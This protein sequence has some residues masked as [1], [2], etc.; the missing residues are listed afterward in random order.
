MRVILFILQK[1]FIQIFRNK[2][3]LPLIFVLPVVQ[4]LIL[5]NAATFELKNINLVVVNH[6]MT[7]T[8]R[9]LVS[10]FEG[11]AF[12]NVK[13][14]LSM[15]EA[16]DDLLGNKANVILYIPANFERELL[17][18][19]RASVQFLINAIDGMAAGLI[20]VY[21]GSIVND[22]HQNLLVEWLDAKTHVTAMPIDVSQRYWFNPNLEY[23][24]YMLPGILVILVTII[25]MFLTAIN[26]VREKEQG[27]I[28]QINVTPILKYQ[29][30]TGKLIPFLII[31]LFELAFGLAI[32][33]IFFDLPMLGSLWLLLLVAVVYLIVALG[34]GL[35]LSAISST[36][37][38]VMFT[39]FFFLLMFILMS[40]IFTPAESMPAWAQK[41]NVI[42]PFKYFMQSIRM[43]LLKGSGFRDVLQELVPLSFYAVIALSFAVWRYRKTV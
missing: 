24:I 20:N 36:Q 29:F 7:S 41:L 32:G 13:H 35:L 21:T 40:G 38:Q 2:T 25:G 42:N 37:Q 26:I 30:I 1:E 18:E 23:S 33:R 43:I 15:E 22:F 39:I 17:R 12:F 28:E 9:E 19:N 5:V 31:A 10:K 34:L 11:S 16:N 4:L 6:D 14:S 8:S 3:M 27:T